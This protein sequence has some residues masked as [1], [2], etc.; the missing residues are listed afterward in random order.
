M[1]IGTDVN[2]LFVNI[3]T[4]TID[5]EFN[6]KIW[7][8]IVK[9]ITWSEKNQIISKAAKIGGGK[10]KA[11]FDI[12]VYNQLYLEKS[13][14]K[15]PFEMTKANVLRLDADFGDLLVDRIVNRKEIDEEES[16]N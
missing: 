2:E 6:N 1:E 13:V 3:E 10:N 12:N 9:D 7:Q 4:E 8:F 16:G 14:V 11:T 15:A 5:V